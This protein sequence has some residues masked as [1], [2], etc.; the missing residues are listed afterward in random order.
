MSTPTLRQFETISIEPGQ[1]DHEA[2][3]YIAWR[4]LREYELLDA[5]RLY[6]E[7]LQKIVR[8]LGAESKYHETITWFYL[9]SIAERM[10]GEAGR[11][12]QAF[13]R[14]NSELFEKEPGW[15][16]RNYSA[17]RL[18]SGREQFVLPDIGLT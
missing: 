15:I 18:N 6:R 8:T 13:K 14:E 12:W 3:V 1:F 16:A 11:D 4:Y 17:G 10:R 9:V 2:H 5:I 7:G